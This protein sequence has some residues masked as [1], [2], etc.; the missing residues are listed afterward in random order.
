MR[1]RVEDRHI[2]EFRCGGM[3]GTRDLENM[4]LTRRTGV[5]M[6]RVS[7]GHEG[8]IDTFPLRMPSHPVA[9]RTYDGESREPSQEREA[10]TPCSSLPLALRCAAAWPGWANLRGIQT[11]RRVLLAPGLCG[12]RLGA[13]VALVRSKLWILDAQNEDGSWGEEPRTDVATLAA[14]RALVSVDDSLPPGL[15]P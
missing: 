8:A 13:N 10:E 7:C 11:H 5:Q 1:G 6:R 15:S 3:A 14:L 12:L 9:M 2:E 4:N